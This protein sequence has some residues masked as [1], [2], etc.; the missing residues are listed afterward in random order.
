M[1]D[2]NAKLKCLDILENYGHRALTFA[3]QNLYLSLDF[4]KAHLKDRDP[5]VVYRFKEGAL[6]ELTRE[7]TDFLVLANKIKLFRDAGA[8]VM[9][10]IATRVKE[11]V[12]EYVG[13]KQREP[14]LKEIASV[15]PLST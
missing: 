8:W 10:V 12:L 4:W 6:P 7:A 15:Q 13:L 1:H 9:P 5:N 2:E 3:E 14:S 11:S